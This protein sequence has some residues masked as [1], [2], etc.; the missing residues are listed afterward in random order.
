MS[1][2]LS[3]CLSLCA[4]TLDGPVCGILPCRGSEVQSVP[5]TGILIAVLCAVIIVS[6][7][8]LTTDVCTVW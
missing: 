2:A 7:V 6:T 8:V 3:I 4:L 1:W 5:G